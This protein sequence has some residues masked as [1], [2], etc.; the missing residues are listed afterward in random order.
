MFP[1][2][3]IEQIVAE[4]NHY[5]RECIATKPDSDTMLDE[6]RAFIGLHVLF[7]IKKLP[8]IRLYWS[9]DP[10]IGVPFIQKGTSRNRFDKL[11]KY[12]HVHNNANQV[13]HEDP[14][15]DKLFKVRPILDHVI[16]CSK[17]ELRP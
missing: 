1:E 6:M 3:L 14:R 7:G 12:F 10:L 8:A 16:Q 11:S 17:M 13:P 5:A 9:E 4:T 2:E 15:H